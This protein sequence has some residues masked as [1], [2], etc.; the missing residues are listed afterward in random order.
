MDIGVL[1]KVGPVGWAEPEHSA[2]S[3]LK[4]CSQGPVRSELPAPDF[5]GGV[6]G[7]RSGGLK[8]PHTL[9]PSPWQLLS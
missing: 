3:D 7:G 6:R 4:L 2:R 9:D 8:C 5:W 1:S